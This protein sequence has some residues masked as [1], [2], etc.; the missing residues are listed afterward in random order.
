MPAQRRLERGDR[1]GAPSMIRMLLGGLLLANLPVAPVRA[2][3]DQRV[4][5]ERMHLGAL[6][7]VAE[8]QSEAGD[9][10]FFAEGSAELGARARVALDA[11]AAWLRAHP[12]VAV[13]VEGH[14]DDW[15]S[16]RDNIELS[17]KRAT[18]VR[19]SLIARGVPAERIATVA[20]G[21]TRRAADCA[22]PMCNAQN[23]RSVTVPNPR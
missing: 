18:A 23:R 13:T 3:G 22:A 11:Q 4:E 15:G 17:Q 7:V 21:R 8:F 10:V 9:R 19:Q 5:D 1:R 14:A 16:A 20:F 2:E 12:S 6:G